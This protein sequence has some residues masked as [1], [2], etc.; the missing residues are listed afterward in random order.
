M[1]LQII[2]LRAQQRL[3]VVLLTGSSKSVLFTLPGLIKPLQT[4]IVVVPFVALKGNLVMRMTAAGLDVLVWYH[5]EEGRAPLTGTALVVVVSADSV[6]SAGFRMYVEGV[7]ARGRLGTIFIDEVHTVIT[8]V[9]YRTKLRGLMGVNRYSCPVVMLTATLPPALEGGFRQAMMLTAVKIVRAA[10]VKANIMYCVLTA[11][12]S[13]NRQRDCEA[14]AH[15]ALMLVQRLMSTMQG[16]QK[17]I[18]YCRAR[19]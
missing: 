13:T 11:A 8:D 6:E 19:E 12:G 2:N 17:G 16:D 14:V 5:L 4:N 15:E 9:S 10:T 7:R 1:I 18:V 3:I